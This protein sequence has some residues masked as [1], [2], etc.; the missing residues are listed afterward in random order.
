M[1]TVSIYA[2]TAHS[3]ALFF[4]TARGGA[5]DRSTLTSYSSG[6]QSWLV[7][8]GGHW[9]T[10]SIS[11]HRAVH[12]VHVTPAGQ[13][14]VISIRAQ[15]RAGGLFTNDTRGL[16]ELVAHGGRVKCNGT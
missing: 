15:R 8:Y 13:R 14:W 2:C 3:T 5:A 4:A 7:S 11:C 12:L 9:H 10:F 6:L 16:E 1:Y